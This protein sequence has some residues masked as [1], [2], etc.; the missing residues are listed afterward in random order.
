[1]TLTFFHPFDHCALCRPTE[2]RFGSRCRRI[3]AM[4][5]GERLKQAQSFVRN[6]IPA[7]IRKRHFQNFFFMRP[8]DISLWG[9][10]GRSGPRS[11]M[12]LTSILW[13]AAALKHCC[14]CTLITAAATFSGIHIS[15]R[16]NELK[17]G[18]HVEFDQFRR[19]GKLEWSEIN[20]LIYF[21]CSSNLKIHLAIRVSRTKNSS[22]RV[23][24]IT[25]CILRLKEQKKGP[26]K[27]LWS[28][29]QHSLGSR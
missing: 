14:C 5:E 27:W 21:I 9:R 25:R 20:N 8:L 17:T 26:L 3:P 11:K 28:P 1:M 12:L 2:K 18:C 4:S 29:F 19:Y 13:W 15:M 22:A 10:W 23:A 16:G 6:D 7:T 24:L